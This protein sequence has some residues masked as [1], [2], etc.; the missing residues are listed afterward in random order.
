MLPLQDLSAKLA[1]DYGQ[2]NTLGDPF[3]RR[4]DPT[5]MSTRPTPGAMLFP[6]TANMKD[7]IPSY[8]IG[9]GLWTILGSGEETGKSYCVIEQQ[10][11][12]GSLC[13]CLVARIWVRQ[14]TEWTR[15]DTR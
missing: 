3:T 4:P 6:F 7:E 8:W 5:K 12:K 9:E 15:L 11:R 14:T 1:A 10:L 2:G 13:G